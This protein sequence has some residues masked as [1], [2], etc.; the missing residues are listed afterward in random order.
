MILLRVLLGGSVDKDDF[1]FPVPFQN[2]NVHLVLGQQLLSVKIT[3]LLSG[4]LSWSQGCCL[5]VSAA[6]SGGD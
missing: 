1:V 6:G 3:G 2:T 5:Y 4:F